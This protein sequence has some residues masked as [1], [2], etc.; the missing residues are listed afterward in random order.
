M[1]IKRTHNNVIW[2]ANP[3]FLSKLSRLSKNYWLVS[4]Y[5]NVKLKAENSRTLGVNSG[6]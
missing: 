2:A 5:K 4:A 6:V 3:D 1:T